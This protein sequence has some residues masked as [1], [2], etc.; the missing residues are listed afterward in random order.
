[1][2][3][4]WAWMLIVQ[5][6]ETT[7]LYTTTATD[8]PTLIVTNHNSA[9]HP[10]PTP[11]ES[12]NGQTR[13]Q[14]QWEHPDAWAQQ[15][16]ITH[17]N[18]DAVST[19]LLGP[20]NTFHI[21]HDP[22]TKQSQFLSTLGS[23]LDVQQQEEALYGGHLL[24]LWCMGTLI[25]LIKRQPK[26][27][28]TPTINKSF[29]QHPLISPCI[30]LLTSLLWQRN[31]WRGT[32]IPAL[33]HDALGTHW[34]IN[35]ANQWHGFLDPLTQ[36]PIEANYQSLDSFVLWGLVQI[37]WFLK[38]LTLYKSC[39]IIFPAISAWGAEYW[40]RDLGIKAPWSWLAGLLFGFSGLID[41]ALLEGH[42][43]QTLTVGLPLSGI[44]VGRYLNE[45]C[46][47]YGVGIVATFGL[48]LFSSSYLGACGLIVFLGLWLGTGSWRDKQTWWIVLGVG[49]LLWI[50]NMWM[51]ESS[52]HQVRT[53]S[54]MTTG[55]VSL[56]NFWGSSPEIDRDGHAIALG[57]STI[58][59]L[60]AMLWK[61]ELSDRNNI[62]KGILI[63]GGLSGILMF[64]PYLNLSY[65]D[66][67]SPLP[68]RW[69]FAQPG[70]SSVGFPI[71]LA[72]PFILAIALCASAGLQRLSRRHHWAW[73]FLPLCL[74]EIDAR[75]LATRQGVWSTET[76]TLELKQDATIFTLHPVT[77]AQTKGSDANIILHML[78]CLAQ[79]GHHKPI[80]NNCLSVDI[81]QSTVKQ[82]Q[83]RLLQRVFTRESV[84]E[85]LKEHQISHLLIYPEL[86]TSADWVRIERKLQQAGTL[87]AKGSQPLHYQVYTAIDNPTLSPPSNLPST[88]TIDFITS[89]DQAKPLLVLGDGI[90][91]ETRLTHQ[92]QQITHQLTLNTDR[93]AIP[94]LFQNTQGSVLWEGTIHPNPT[95]DQIVIVEG[96]GPQ[97]RLPLL[98][99]PPH[100]Y[101]GR[102]LIWLLFG[103]LGILG[104]LLRR[105]VFSP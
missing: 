67:L 63:F 15:I 64:G 29:W 42:I 39:M 22:N 65:I 85:V 44:F 11:I 34:M 54:N 46:F 104:F 76:P 60:L 14:F 25:L 93:Q 31:L 30:F 74:W 77:T 47:K 13:W 24:W 19:V 59:I 38:P 81:A 8:T 21:Y 57:I 9:Y 17:T 92:E 50:H 28:F 7:L 90:L 86:F 68:T 56:M 98:N 49:P 99:S 40:A 75:N 41:N 66:T 43:Y 12:P 87:V 10:K 51:S 5:A 37:G 102:T 6:A 82:I 84:F 101:Q 55:S 105:K 95:S 3:W 80:A 97:T 48:A 27:Q 23:P 70:L 61:S 79:T 26:S 35:S 32:G 73:I 58:G 62:W 53:I 36:Y 33:Y 100:L 91:S 96:E 94:L 71:R 1:M 89:P 69:L 83:K 72:H 78:D 16:Q 18:S 4:L 45:P 20:E 103:S 88:V 2:L 52:L